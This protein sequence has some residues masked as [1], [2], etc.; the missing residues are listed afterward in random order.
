VDRNAFKPRSLTGIVE[1]F[2]YAPLD[3]VS[4]V[5]NNIVATRFLAPHRKK[6]EAVSWALRAAQSSDQGDKAR[7]IQEATEA[8]TA[9][10]ALLARPG[11]ME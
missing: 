3:L 4:G 8:V 10:Q 9:M 5:F 11:A 7:A 6:R 1:P 2:S